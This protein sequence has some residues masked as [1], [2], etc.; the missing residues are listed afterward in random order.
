MRRGWKHALRDL[1]WM[2]GILNMKKHLDNY[3]DEFEFRVNSK[4]ISNPN[5]FDARLNVCEGRLTYKAL[6]NA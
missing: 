2:V 5:R 4:H 6:T 3:I 1:V